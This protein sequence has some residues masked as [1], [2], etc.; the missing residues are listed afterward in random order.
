MSLAAIGTGEVYAWGTGYLGCAPSKV[1]S[2]VLNSSN[3]VASLQRA[4]VGEDVNLRKSR[5]P[6]RVPELKRCAFVFYFII[7][8]LKIT[9]SIHST[10]C[11]SVRKVACGLDAHC[12]AVTSDGCLFT[13]G[14]GSFGRLGH[15]DDA[16]HAYPRRVET[17]ANR[18]L[19][20]LHV[21]CGEAHTIAIAQQGKFSFTF[22]QG[23][24]QI[25]IVYISYC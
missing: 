22:K 3:L 11:E 16:D 23:E 19:V 7:S 4:D 12:A 25:L 15:G 13:W 17:F 9:H 1:T 2:T 24:Q 14:K 5:I 18:K 8:V 21:S 10:L 20:V 6:K